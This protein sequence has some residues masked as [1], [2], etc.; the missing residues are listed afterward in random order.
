MYYLQIS[1]AMNGHY[2]LLAV[3]MNIIIFYKN[4]VNFR[5]GIFKWEGLKLKG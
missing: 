4:E 1:S 5:Y 2:M 3:E